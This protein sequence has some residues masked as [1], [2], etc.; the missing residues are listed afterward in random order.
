MAKREI[1]SFD[2]VNQPYETVRDVLRKDAAA[3]FRS[4]TQ[5]AEARTGELVASLSVEVKGFEL[6]KEIAIRIGEVQETPGPRLSHVTH[7]EL[8]WQAKEAPGLFP[9]MKADLSVYP[10][11]GKETQIDLRGAYEPPLGPLGGA[12]DAMVGHRIAEASV[13]RFVSAVAERLRA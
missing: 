10:L 11:S 6:A 5:V 8:E 4:A 13:H 9:T 1:R 3:I 12:I 7:I 2:Y